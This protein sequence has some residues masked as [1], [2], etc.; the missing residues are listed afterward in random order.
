VRTPTRPVEFDSHLNFRL[1]SDLRRQL[2]A[3]AKR[4]RRRVTDMVRIFV[5]DGIAKASTD[6]EAA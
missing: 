3:V 4:V 6:S 1:P 5:Q 2:E